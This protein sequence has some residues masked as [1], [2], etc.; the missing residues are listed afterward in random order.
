MLGVLLLWL[1]VGL[2]T[3]RRIDGFTAPVYGGRNRAVEAL[4]KF[5]P[6]TATAL[7]RPYFTVFYGRIRP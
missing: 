3:V 4:S 7:L 6:Y 2:S 1:F 5:K